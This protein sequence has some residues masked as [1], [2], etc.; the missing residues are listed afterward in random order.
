MVTRH[1]SPS[2]L[3]ALL[4]AVVFGSLVSCGSED[5]SPRGVLVITMDTTRADHLSCYGYGRPTTPHIDQLAAES[6]MFLN[7]TSTSSWTLPSHASLFTGKLPSSHG[8]QFDPEGPLVL[9]DALEGGAF[10][11]YRARGLDPSE[12]TMA[13]ALRERGYR[14]GAVVAGPWLK[15]AFGLDLGFDHYDDDNITH[16]NGRNAE[17]VTDAALQWLGE[18]DTDPFFLFLNYYDPHAPY[19]PS[20]EQAKGF[21]MQV[22]VEALQSVPDSINQYD[23]E[24]HFMDRHLGRLFDQLRQR[25]DFDDLL[26]VLTADH[27]DLMGEH[28]SFGHGRSLT[29]AEIHIPLIVKYPAANA[30]RGN[31]QAPVQL[32]D[33][34]AEVLKQCGCEVPVDIQGEAFGS[35]QNPTIAEV[36]PLP[37]TT[38]NGN[39]RVLIE[40]DMKLA[41]NSKGNSALYNLRQDPGEIQNLFQQ[42]GGRARAMEQ[43]LT[44]FLDAV[45]RSFAEGGDTIIDDE[46]REAL[47]GFGYTG[48]SEKKADRDH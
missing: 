14:T 10:Q 31:R 34:Y 21:W 12:T 25:P 46:T 30:Q 36:Y 33:V 19:K 3:L 23:A 26:I 42:Q 9:S 1:N 40:D 7:A 24:I 48:D 5:L 11:Q 44:Q 47:E 16:V 37:F 6:V 35:K 2:L 41:W 38:E 17:D 39:W 8:A 18:V 20:V 43:R 28:G 29:Q 15:R 45:K 32:T 22:G 27:G 13:A 4:P